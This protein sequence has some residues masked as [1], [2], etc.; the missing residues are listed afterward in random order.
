MFLA[1][2]S[3]DGKREFLVKHKHTSYWRITWLP[4]EVILEMSSHNRM[5]IQ[6]WI[7]KVGEPDSRNND[8]PDT[9]RSCG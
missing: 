5:R 1:A 4:E 9:V 6:R 8:A 7:E 2:R 3:R